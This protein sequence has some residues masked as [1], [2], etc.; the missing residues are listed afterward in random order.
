MQ[1]LYDFASNLGFSIANFSLDGKIHR[2][3]RD[4]KKNAWYVGYQCFSSKNGEAFYICILGDW[5]TAEKH[6]FKPNKTTF[7]KEDRDNIKKKMEEAAKKAEVERELLQEDAC[8]AA[9]KIIE[10]SRSIEKGCDYLDKKRIPLSGALSIMETSGRAVVIPMRDVD[11]KLWGLQRI[12]SDGSKF[13]LTGQKTQNTMFVMGDIEDN[14]LYICE[15]FATGASIRLAT[16]KTVIVAFNAGNLTHVARDI[17]RKYPNKAITICGDADAS[18]VGQTAAQEAAKVGMGNAIFPRFK[19]DGDLTD[20]NDLH[21]EEGIET[22]KSQ[23]NSS[24]KPEAIGYIPLGIDEG[25]HYFYDLQIRN[26]K[27]I[28]AF[29]DNQ[30]LELMPLIYWDMTYPGKRGPNW[31]QAIS[32]LIEVSKKAGPFDSFRIRG[33]G[34]WFDC[35]RTVINTGDTL[36][37][38]GA[39]VSLTTLKSRYVYIKTKN[40][41]PNIHTRPL[42]VKECD[43]ILGICELFKWKDPQKSHLY[44]SGWIA[45]ARI[46][47]ALPIRPHVWL[48]TSAGQG[49]S[50]IMGRFINKALGS[51]SARLFLQGGSTEAGIRQ[52]VK[53]DSLPIIFDEFENN[54]EASRERTQSLI[55]LLRQSWSHTQGHVVK[56]SAGGT[57]THYALSFAALVSSIRVSLDNDADRSRFAILELAPHGEDQFHWR[58]LDEA[59][60]ID[61]EYGERLF[62]RMTRMIPTV[63]KSYKVMSSALSGKVS[64]RFGQQYGMLLAGWYALLADVPMTDEIAADIANTLDFSETRTEIL[65]SADEIEAFFH[66]MYSQVT[67]E[68][69]E[70]N[71][72]TATVASIIEEGKYLTEL[73]NYGIFVE[74]D[75]ISIANNHASLKKSIFAQTRWATN[76]SKSL[77]RIPGAISI[78]K[79]FDNQQHRCISIPRALLAHG[80]D[81]AQISSHPN[82]KSPN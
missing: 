63:L 57:A 77:A 32:D 5:K 79:R 71:R 39:E 3:D 45:I 60:N 46:S 11:G 36:L 8:H 80:T 10:Q 69:G 58:K 61:E 59:L 41:M 6:E 66:I 19:K 20:F 51:E 50:T 18:N 9:V 65:E 23:L 24:E 22:L 76:W 64:S 68:Y 4:G 38:D 56:G 33:T 44:L 7:S 29:S 21:T 82:F 62:S 74:H 70:K 2:F 30:L 49:K 53:A 1:E 35:G 67:I 31:K 78:R 48:T 73:K 42:T 17:R 12:F 54:G 52:S 26:I 15:G 75:F 72:K 25:T 40:R 43:K 27:K 13:F 37:C 34:V 14:F 28:G 81:V 16:S 47:G 55:E